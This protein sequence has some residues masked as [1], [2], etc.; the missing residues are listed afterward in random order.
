MK[1]R[2]KNIGRQMPLPVSNL[3]RGTHFGDSLSAGFG[4]GF[5]FS[6]PFHVPSP[7]AA[8]SGPGCNSTR[9]AEVSEGAPLFRTTSESAGCVLYVGDEVCALNLTIC[10]CWFRMRSHPFQ[11]SSG[12]FGSE[13]T[14]S[15]G[16]RHESSKK[17][18]IGSI[19]EPRNRSM[20]SIICCCA[21]GLE[22]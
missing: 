7:A 13:E 11:S 6:W 20:R 10:F 8:I 22:Q 9:S 19:Y 16:R 14:S 17:D 15:R 3:L 5:V 1:S 21:A 12:G 2:M 18:I 4:Y